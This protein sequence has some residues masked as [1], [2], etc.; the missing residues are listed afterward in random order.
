MTITQLNSFLKITELGSFSA[1]ANELG[2]A[3]STITT[4]IK[5][6]EEELDCRLFDR[7]GKTIVLT[8]Q[9]EKLV[10]YAEKMLQL[11]REI[12]L[13]ITDEV[14]PAG[15]LKIGVSESL[16]YKRIP[17]ALMKYK[18]ELPGIEMQLMFIT[19]NTFPELLQKGELDLVYTLNPYI[20]DERLTM[21]YKH[22]ETL[23]FFASK[24]HSLSGKKIKEKDLANCPLLLTDRNCSFRNMLLTDLSKCGVEPRILIETG[25]KEVLKQ[26]ASNG[27]GVAFIPDMTVEKE[28]KNNRL[29]R[30]DWR[31]SA[32][33]IYSQI[34]IHRDKH[35]SRAISRF[36]DIISEAD[37]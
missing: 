31:G 10:T 33:P 22:A 25:S 13:E 17:E 37:G 18:N 29:K 15:V 2:Y 34:F 28:I 16:C 23:G 32:F 5:Q 21:L 6:L 7:L 27:L 8:A 4:Q 14:E 11:E 12:H 30:L 26:F 1:A 3:Q 20:E 19:H 9:G 35:V 36:V 24:N